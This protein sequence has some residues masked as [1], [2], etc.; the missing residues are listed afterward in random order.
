MIFFKI[1]IT[2]QKTL[3][4]VGTLTL[5][6][7]TANKGSGENVSVKWRPTANPNTLDSPL[8][9]WAGQKSSWSCQR[10]MRLWNELPTDCKCG[11]K[12]V[13]F[14]KDTVLVPSSKHV[15]SS[16]QV[17][18]YLGRICTT[19]PKNSLLKGYRRNFLGSQ[20]QAMLMRNFKFILQHHRGLT[21]P[22]SLN[23]RGHDSF[24]LF[25][26]FILHCRRVSHWKLQRDWNISGG[27]SS[28]FWHLN[29]IKQENS[30]TVLVKLSCM[31]TK[32]SQNQH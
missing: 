4:A 32:Q 17:E 18:K 3:A 11:S 15:V 30:S 28:G 26:H 23:W 27:K 14:Q 25:S 8:S 20:I 12:A 7:Y 5:P 16:W 9:K 10:G 13:C 2:S 1:I 6:N 21:W 29:E 31:S 24:S 22:L 19:V